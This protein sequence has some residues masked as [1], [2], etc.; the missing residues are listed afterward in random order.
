VEW[1]LLLPV[2]IRGVIQLTQEAPSLP[3][4]ALQQLEAALLPPE[5]LLLQ[6]ERLKLNSRLN[7]K[8]EPLKLNSKLSSKGRLNLNQRQRQFQDQQ[9]LPYLMRVLYLRLLHHLA[10]QQ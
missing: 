6:Q 5:G 8:E 9:M 10:Q 3:E 2:M 1:G 7:N 4:G